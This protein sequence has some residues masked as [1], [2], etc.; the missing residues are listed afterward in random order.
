MTLLAKAD[1][2][3]GERCL[4]SAFDPI[5][6]LVINETQIWALH[7]QRFGFITIMQKMKRKND[8]EKYK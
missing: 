4:K 7:A 1:R 6:V 3:E 8:N 5:V 2:G